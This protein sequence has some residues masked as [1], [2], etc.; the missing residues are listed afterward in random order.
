MNQSETN[1][2]SGVN[3]RRAYVLGALITGLCIGW[4]AGYATRS[5]SVSKLKKNLEMAE[6]FQ[7]ALERNLGLMQSGDKVDDIPYIYE[8][9][10]LHLTKK[11]EHFEGA[12]RY[13]M[14][15]PTAVP[16]P[17]CEILHFEYSQA[18][19]SPN[20]EGQPRDFAVLI[21]GGIVCTKRYGES[22]QL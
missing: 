5:N 13:V 8:L 14:D 17:D 21:V 18:D 6:R 16:P 3:S 2:L 11:D 22:L 9:A 10:D 20:G 15:D 4:V 12:Y 19:G 7:D 1:H